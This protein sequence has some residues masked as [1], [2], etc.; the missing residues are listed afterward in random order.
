M[1]K[2]EKS[3]RGIFWTAM[4]ESIAVK[5]APAITV[6]NMISITQVPMFAGRKLFIA[7]EVA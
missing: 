1:L 6:V 4:P 5:V 7:T 2:T 3:R